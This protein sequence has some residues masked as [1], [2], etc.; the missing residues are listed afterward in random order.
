MLLSR[1]SFC[2][3]HAVSA[4]DPRYSLRGILLEPSGR[5]VATDGY[6]LALYDPK[7]VPA[8]EEFPTIAGVKG[9]KL[10][11]PVILDATGCELVRKAIPKRQT[12]P[13]LEHVLV[14]GAQSNGTVPM[15][16][17]DLERPQTFQVPVLDG[18][19]PRYENVIPKTAPELVQRFG[20]A[21]LERALKIAKDAGAKNV[22]MALY[23]EWASGPA[24]IEAVTD[25]GEVSILVMPMAR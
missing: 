21:L 20:I 19:F 22:D 1:E 17:T 24:V 25:A 7:F 10:D 8:E 15:A 2:V 13:V 6:M 4:D 23:G 12:I 9:S 5:M 16:V 14:D 3:R 18:Q 11:K